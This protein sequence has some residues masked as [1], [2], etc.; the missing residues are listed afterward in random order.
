MSL[1]EPTMKTSEQ[2]IAAKA[3]ISDPTKRIS[4]LG[5]TPICQVTDTL[6]AQ[7]KCLNLLGKASLEKHNSGWFWMGDSSPH[8]EVMAVWD[9]AIK[10]AIEEEA[11]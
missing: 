10:L 7:M 3:L 1:N 8:A 2:L 9:E 11:S 5:Q 6:K 4:D